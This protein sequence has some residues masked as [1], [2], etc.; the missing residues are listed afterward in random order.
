M[1]IEMTSNYVD[2]P[3]KAYEVYIKILSFNSYMFAP[4]SNLAIVVSAED[5]NGTALLLEPNL[6]PTVFKYQNDLYK[7]NLPIL[8]LDSKNIQKYYQNLLDKKVHFTQ[9]T[10]KN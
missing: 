7:Q 4:E 6:N 9:K 3:S 2:D 5:P 10:Y 8:V 1:K